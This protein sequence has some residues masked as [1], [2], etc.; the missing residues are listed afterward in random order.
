MGQN[1]VE[2]SQAINDNK[3]ILGTAI[4]FAYTA[5][6]DEIKSFVSDKDKTIVIYKN[7][8]PETFRRDK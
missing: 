3:Q 8:K 6:P 5:D 4:S 7:K 1:F 2:L